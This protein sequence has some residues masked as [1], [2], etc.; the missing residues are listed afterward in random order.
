MSFIVAEYLNTK[1][2]L[3]CSVWH[4]PFLLA[5][6]TMGRKSFEVKN[7]WSVVKFWKMFALLAW[8]RPGA[9][10]WHTPQHIRHH[11]HTPHTYIT[12]T[13]RDT[14]KDTSS[15]QEEQHV[16]RKASSLKSHYKLHYWCTE[17]SS[18]RAELVYE[19]FPKSLLPI[20]TKTALNPSSFRDIRD[21]PFT[22]KPFS[23]TTCTHNTPFSK[24]KI[25]TCSNDV[26]SWL[27]SK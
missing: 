18:I 21:K 9:H 12:H 3:V 26:C 27:P 8:G 15:T 10:T 20:P 25:R 6:A 2:F 13:C 5:D 24:I 7:P 23:H 4:R 19:M 11:T 16:R 14:C 22:P 1:W 17:C